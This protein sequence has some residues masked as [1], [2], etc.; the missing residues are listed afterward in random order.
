LMSQTTRMPGRIAKPS[1]R[2]RTLVSVSAM[3]AR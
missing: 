2:L 3:R 1:G